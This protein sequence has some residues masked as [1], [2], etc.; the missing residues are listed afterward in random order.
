MDQPSAAEIEKRLVEAV[1]R[2]P[3]FP[4]SAQTVLEL[5]SDIDSPSRDLVAV[6]EKDPVMTAKILKIINSAYYSLP[7]K[8]TSVGQ[9]VVYMGSNT[10]KNLALSFAALGALPERNPLNFSIQKY[11]IHSLVTA[12]MARELCSIAGDKDVEPSDAYV[13]GLLHDFGKVVLAQY[14]TSEYQQIMEKAIAD[15]IPL[16]QA[17]KEI[18]GV[19]HALVGAMLARRWRFPKELVRCIADHHKRNATSTIL[20][21]CVRVANQLCRKFKLGNSQNPYRSGE[22]LVSDR[23]G[24]D[25]DTVTKSLGDIQQYID[26]ATMFANISYS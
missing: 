4:S 13:A 22:K 6:I 14:M 17:E 15:K 9:A 11:L 24:R 20:L 2:M 5:S 23:F 25:F 10:I 7:N 8:I 16:H 12:C 18:L 21:D 3:A 1:E 19:D 26:E